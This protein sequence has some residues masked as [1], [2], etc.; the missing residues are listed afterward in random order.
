MSFLSP[1]TSGQAGSTPGASAGGA[2][3]HGVTAVAN[4]SWG[5]ADDPIAGTVLVIAAHNEDVEW[6]QNQ[7]FQPVIMVKG[8]P[9]GTPNNLETNWGREA[10]S[11]LHFIVEHYDDLPPRMIFV[12]GHNESWHLRDLTGALK[13]IDPM[14]YT[15][16]TLSN[17]F[18]CFRADF[19]TMANCWENANMTPWLGALP[20]EVGRPL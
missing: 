12:H 4:S 17:M 16:A 13:V 14:S 15:F 7:P 8:R 3:S 10:S 11:Y 6:V 19:V 5:P 18:V 2:S 9:A 1:S 20:V